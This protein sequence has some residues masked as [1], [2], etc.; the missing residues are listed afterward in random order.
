MR[1]GERHLRE[2]RPLER[3]PT[4][5]TPPGPIRAAAS[6]S[7]P[8]DLIADLAAECA[9]RIGISSVQNVPDFFAVGIDPALVANAGHA[10]GRSSVR[11]RSTLACGV[12]AAPCGVPGGVVDRYKAKIADGSLALVLADT[13]P[14]QIEQLKEGYSAGQVGQ[15]PFE[16][17]YQGMMAFQQMADGGAAPADP[18]YTGLDVCTPERADTCIAK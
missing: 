2:A 11:A 15:R 18:T 1:S 5:R 4:G 7:A 3:Y 9:E 16:M 8:W 6:P 17:G 14:T 10:N 13:L 12:A